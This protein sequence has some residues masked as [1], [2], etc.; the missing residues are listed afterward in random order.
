VADEP[1]TGES[2][3]KN[4]L[5]KKVG[6]FA[7]WEWGLLTL[8]GV[9]LFLYMRNKNLT[10]GSTSK[11]QAA[12]SVNQVTQ[13]GE[14]VDPVTGYLQ[15]S[16]A[17]VAALSAMYD[18]QAAGN[19]TPTGGSTGPAAATPATTYSSN[20]AWSAA[21]IG[22]LNSLGE[23]GASRAIRDYIAGQ[24]LTTQEQ[25]M[26]NA[27]VSD[28]GPPPTAPTPS[29]ATMTNGG[30]TYPAP[31]PTGQQPA[32]WQ[33]HQPGEKNGKG[34]TPPSPES[35]QNPWQPP[36]GAPNP[37]PDGHVNPGGPNQPM[38]GQQAPGGNNPGNS[39]KPS[40]RTGSGT[41]SSNRNGHG[42]GQGNGQPY[43]SGDGNQP[44]GNGAQPQG[45]GSSWTSSSKGKGH[46][47]GGRG[48]L[49]AQ[50]S[51]NGGGW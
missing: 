39:G 8:I 31:S 42:S 37:N 3:G 30:G 44:Q 1:S 28:L 6:P 20:S 18:L 9:G 5:T 4:E 14:L 49:A 26:V 34:K 46:G 32:P 19:T 16:A 43:Q 10:G 50:G 11:S 41:K 15:G 45:G 29:T 21:A 24:N 27:A 48:N 51:G 2:G 12:G 36:G 40:Y 7:V 38:P 17:D 47:Q 13:N 33:P 23:S 22:Y 35:G 25:S